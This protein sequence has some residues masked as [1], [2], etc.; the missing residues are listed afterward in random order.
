MSYIMPYISAYTMPYIM[1]VFRLNVRY[2]ISAY[3]GATLPVLDCFSDREGRLTGRATRSNPEPLTPGPSC[4]KSLVEKVDQI[5][6][7]G[8]SQMTPACA[9]QPAALGV[10]SGMRGVDSGVRGVVCACQPAAYILR[11][12]CRR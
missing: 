12:I 8:L 7:R 6:P 4:R 1:P 10:D 9:C 5:T 3:I 2:V 11:G